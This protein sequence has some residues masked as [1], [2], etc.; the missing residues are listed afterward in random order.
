[1]LRT[2]LWM[3]ALLI[4]L[5]GLILVEGRWFAPFYP[6]LL[7]AALAACLLAARELRSMLDPASRPRGFITYLGIAS[8]ILANWCRALEPGSDG[9]R[10][11]GWVFTIAGIVVF[12]TEI[13]AFTRPGFIAERLSQT[14]LILF[15]LGLL[16]SF[17]LQL[18]WLPE[19]SNLAIALTVFVAKGC[20]I[21][22]YFTGK[23]LTGRV[24]GRTPMTPLLSPKKTWQGAV[25]GLLFACAVSVA[26]GRIEPI[27]SGAPAAIGFGLVVGMAG[28]LGDLSESLLKRD[29]QTK[30][31]S[32]AVPGFGGVLDVIDSLLFAGPVAY[33]W[34]TYW[35]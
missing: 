31:A 15:Y 23:F 10:A 33:L 7:L 8:L 29:R 25:G 30:D 32:A 4:G 34:F 35:K 28:M 1:M 13:R 12:L 26:L 24:L 9:F 20:D 11:V 5:A 22:A 3:G 19:Y 6:V 14:L 2:R 21:G 17:L 27:F 16:P 18:R